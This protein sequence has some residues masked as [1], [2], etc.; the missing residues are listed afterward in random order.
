MFGDSCCVVIHGKKTHMSKQKKVFLWTAFSSKPNRSSP[1]R[2]RIPLPE[3]RLKVAQQ[4]I[5]LISICLMEIKLPDCITNALHNI[6]KL[7]HPRFSVMWYPFICRYWTVVTELVNQI[8]YIKYKSTL[9]IPHLFIPIQISGCLRL[10]I[11]VC[12]YLV[13][14]NNSVSYN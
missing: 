13:P 10:C 8:N 14:N 9:S 3:I 7:D 6:S 5:R 11:I 12:H 2:W 4:L 1:S